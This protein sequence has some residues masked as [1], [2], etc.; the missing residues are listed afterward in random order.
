MVLFITQEEIDKGDARVYY[1]YEGIPMEGLFQ[2][3]LHFGKA[4]AKMDF[5]TFKELWDNPTDRGFFLLA[6]HDQFLMA[7]LMMLATF[8]F[9]NV[10][11]AEHPWNIAEV[12]RE[13]K[14]MGPLQQVAFNVIEGSTV[15]AQFIGLGGGNQ[16]ILQGMAS[17]PPTLTAVKRFISTN[18]RM[19]NGKQSLPFT[20]A[21]NIGAI[22][23]FQG[24][25][26]DIDPR[27]NQ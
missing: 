21:Q 11:D 23:T 4:L 26:K 17:N 5:K 18:A 1:D 22:R 10:A 9:G 15:D 2:E 3:F 16:G 13:M 6:L 25:L 7:L 12:S 24:V 14:K 19:I 27:Q 20:A 8:V